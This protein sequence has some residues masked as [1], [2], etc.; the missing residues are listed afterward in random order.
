M[1]LRT[2]IFHSGEKIKYINKEFSLPIIYETTEEYTDARSCGQISKNYFVNNVDFYTESINHNTCLNRKVGID[3]DGNIKNCPSMNES[4]GNISE[5]SIEESITHPDFKKY[6]N[7][8][9]DLITICMDCEFRHVCMDCRAYR[10]DP[11]DILS[12]PLKCGYD[13][14]TSSWSDWAKSPLKQKTIIHY[15]LT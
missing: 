11:N 15:G 5:V 1:H 9:K 3:K 8:K 6:W 12:K 7:I 2:I 13:P 10:E 4:Y 14:Y